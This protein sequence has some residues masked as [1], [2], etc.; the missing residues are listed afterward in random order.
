MKRT[1]IKLNFLEWYIT[2]EIE[3]SRDETIIDFLFINI[4]IAKPKRYGRQRNK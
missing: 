2:P 1:K 4:I 3:R